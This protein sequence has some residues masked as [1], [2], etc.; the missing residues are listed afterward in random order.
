MIFFGTE[1][2]LR[3]EVKEWILRQESSVKA[4]VRQRERT[5]ECVRERARASVRESVR[6]SV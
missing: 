4:V 2:A 6:A 1:G 5:H 3:R